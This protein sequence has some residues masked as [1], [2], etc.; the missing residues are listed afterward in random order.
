MKAV[1]DQPV[2]SV[3]C[4]VVRPEYRGQ[5][6]A[7]ALLRGAIVYARKHG[8]KLL[9]AYPVDKPGVSNDDAMWFGAKSMYD[10]AGFEEVAR[11]KPFRPIVRLTPV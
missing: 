8:A 1:D 2:W 4:F 3:I 10:G 6:V 9:E 7:H 5:G 11:R